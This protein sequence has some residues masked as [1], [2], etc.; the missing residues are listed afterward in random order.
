VPETKNIDSPAGNGITN[1]SKEPDREPSTE[2][3]LVYRTTVPANPNLDAQITISQTTGWTERDANGK[4]V[5]KSR[6]PVVLHE[7]VESVQRTS[8][9]LSLRGAHNEAIRQETPL[10][11]TLVAGSLR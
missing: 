2:G 4:K 5:L 3:K 11:M 1:V 10:P 6:A 7:F 8:N 9:G